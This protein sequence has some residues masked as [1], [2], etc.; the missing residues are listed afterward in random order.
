VGADAL[1]GGRGD[2][3][4]AG[5][6]S[7]D[8]LV[9]G[10]GDDL[11]AGGR[12][13]DVLIGGTGADTLIGGLDHDRFDFNGVTDST[14][15]AGRAL[16]RGFDDV[17]NAAGD[18][19]DLVGIDASAGGRDTAFDFVGTAGFSARGQLRVFDQGGATVIAGNTTGDLGADVLIVVDDGSFTAS[20]W[21]TADFLL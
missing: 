13:D 1:A 2:D 9:G 18:L 17:G 10:M 3:A 15:G 16:I 12:G 7:A 11:L 4:L 19:V 8:T 5:G 21:R 6:R 14:S 20:D